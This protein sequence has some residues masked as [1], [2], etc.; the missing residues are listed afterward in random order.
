MKKNIPICILASTCLLWA[1]TLAAAGNKIPGSF[2]SADS[3]HSWKQDAGPLVLDD[4]RA[5][6]R[7][8]A[9]IGDGDFKLRVI[10]TLEKIEHTAASL[11]FD[12]SHLGLD[13]RGNTLFVSGPHFAGKTVTLA[14]TKGLIEAGKPFTVEIIRERGT[15][16][17]L[18]DGK[19][20]DR[21]Q[22]WDEPIQRIGLR[23]WRNRMTVENLVL[24]GDVNKPVLPP[25]PAGLALY[26]SGSDGYHTYRI[27]AI[28]VTARG[29]VLAFCEGRK[30]SRIDSGNIDL[31]LKRSADGGKTWSAQQLIW[32]DGENT[33][34][35]PCVVVDRDS[36]TI[37]LLTTWNR[38]DD[39]ER[40]IIARKSQDTRRVFVTCSVD[41]GVSWAKPVEITTRG[42]TAG[43]G[44]VCHRPGQWNPD[45]TRPSQRPPGDSLRSHRG[46]NRSLLFPRHLLRRPRRHLATGRQ[47]P[48]APGKRVRGR[49]T[50]RRQTLAQHA[51]L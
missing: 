23:P 39:R 11:V 37:W 21:R 40:E 47:D 5:I 51:Q 30:D 35:N 27:P 36:G 49:G 8:G 24:E 25:Q 14:E 12:S 29:T 45:S 48:R 19:E 31:L 15:A 10:L 46:R 22:N 9:A 7:A 16:R 26:V 13:G 20:I 32:D 2:D 33:C 41:D 42:E 38:G 6:F 43:L 28:C 50:R 18:V 3:R 17:F 34:G 4:P 1:V 44:L